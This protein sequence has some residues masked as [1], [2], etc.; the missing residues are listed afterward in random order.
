MKL[1]FKYALFILL[2]GT[3]I[4]ADH[5]RAVEP[6]PSDR[7]SSELSVRY[8]NVPWT[9]THH[10]RFL[11][12]THDKRGYLLN[13][14]D[15]EKCKAVL[16]SDQFNFLN[17]C[18]MEEF[19]NLLRFPLGAVRCIM[20][21]FGLQE[22]H[23][24]LHLNNTEFTTL[25]GF[26]DSRIARF[27]DNPLKFSVILE[28]GLKSFQ[29]LNDDQFNNVFKILPEGIKE[30]KRFTPEQISVLL[31]TEHLEKTKAIVC[32]LD[33]YYQGAQKLETKPIM[34][35]LDLPLEAVKS[36]MYRSDVQ[37]HAPFLHLNDDEFTTLLRFSKSR[38]ARFIDNP[39][40]FPS[41][42]EIGLKSFQQLN[43]DQFNNVFEL[44]SERI[45]ELKRFTPEQIPVFLETENLEKT[46]A[47]VFCLDKHYQA[48][49]KLENKPI[50]RL[51]DLPT[52][53]VHSL[54][55][56]SPQEHA[57]FLHLND[58][59][60]TTLLGFSDSRI[61]Q[62]IDSPRVFSSLLEIGLKSFQPLNDNQFNNVFELSSER[63]KELKRFTP[64]QIPVLLDTKHLGKTNAIVYCL[65]QY[66]QAS[67]KVET[68]PIMRLLDLPTEAV[69]SLMYGFPQQHA[70][71]L[72]L[73]DDE[74]NEFKK[75]SWNQMETLIRYG[76]ILPDI[77]KLGL[78][79]VRNLP[80]DESS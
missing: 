69:Q 75:F 28:I 47:I 17:D 50:M 76:E 13:T 40:K 22:R 72:H 15:A 71:F 53:A 65:D 57:P 11:V 60:F 10:T 7:V 24:F 78:E 43:D 2:C 73:N 37:E 62:F 21:T 6:D 19:R 66:Y 48:S 51:L 23:P 61:V 55:Y 1:K 27:I 12:F 3:F 46:K 25:L 29:Q 35:L 45:K 30:L 67:Q 79:Q 54:M 42:L 18:S 34:R 77:L 59:E 36:L 33:Q 20:N 44:S 38:I 74:F 9:L 52:E 64:E 32:C 26:S 68:K 14:C 39:L 16:S 8:P 49:Q 5:V 80:D 63:I 58:D 41:L 70:P 31:D 4:A 56:R